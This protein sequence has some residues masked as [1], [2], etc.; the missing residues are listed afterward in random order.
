MRLVDAFTELVAAKSDDDRLE[1]TNRVA[2]SCVRCLRTLGLRDE[3][4]NL[5]QLLLTAV[6][7]GGSMTDLKV[8]YAGRPEQWLK[9]LQTLLRIA[10]G[11]LTLGRTDQ[12]DPILDEARAELLSPA[13][14]RP[15]PLAFTHLMTAYIAAAGQGPA[16]SGLQRLGELFCT[17]NPAKVTNAFVTAPFF[18]R[19]HLNVAEEVV[20]AV[21]EMLLATPPTA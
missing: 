18:S 5:L 17:I 13:G 2:G 9:A 12:A 20:L 15:M 8:K 4:D 16:E 6:L 11:W 3:M 7:G 19:L 14:R 21:L 10:G 1:L